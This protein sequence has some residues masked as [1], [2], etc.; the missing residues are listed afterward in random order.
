MTS[1]GLF[2]I[3]GVRNYDRAE[4]LDGVTEEIHLMRRTLTGLGLTEMFPFADAERSHERLE[5]ELY[6]WALASEESPAY[7]ETLLIY[8]TG[9]GMTIDGGGQFRLQLSDGHP[10]SPDLLLTV[11]NGRKSLRQVVLIL[12]ACFSEPGVDDSLLEMRRPNTRTAQMDFW[13]I[14]SSRRLEEAAQRTFAREFA[15]AVERNSR[16]SWSISHFEPGLIAKEVDVA[17]GPGQTVWL[18]AGHSAAGCRV[19]P[20][21]RYQPGSPPT[22]LPIADDWAAAARG[23]SAADRPGFFFTG[24]DDEL[25]T[26]RE[27]IDGDGADPIVIVSGAAG[28]G[29]S[30]LLG[31]LVLTAVEAEALPADVRLRW[32]ALSSRI[33]AARGSKTSVLIRQLARQLGLPGGGRDDVLGALRALPGRTGVVLDQLEGIDE[34]CWDDVL[35][36][37]ADVPGV[38]LVLGLSSSSQTKVRG[39]HRTIDLDE[40]GDR[41]DAEVRDYLA[42]R[43][44]LAHPEAT[45]QEL[46]RSVS[47]AARWGF[48]FPVAVVGADAYADAVARGARLSGPDSLAE[49]AATAAARRVCRTI[50]HAYLGDRAGVVIDALC[51]LCSYDDSIAVP[52]REWAAAASDP[53]GSEV[54]VDDVTTAAAAL[55]RF[56][57]RVPG[58]GGLDRWRPRFPFHGSADTPPPQHFLVRIPQIS[59]PSQVDWAAV[60]PAVRTL[61]AEG[62]SL[63]TRHGRMLDDPD[64]LLAVPPDLVSAAVRRLRNDAADR[65]RRALVARAVPPDGSLADRAL[66]LGVAA[67][68]YGLSSVA[69]ALA[70]SRHRPAHDIAWVQPDRPRT[71]RFT[72]MSTALQGAVA[73]TVDD[74]DVLGFWSLVD[75]ESTRPEVRVPGVPRTV[76]AAMLHGRVVCLVATWQGEIWAVDCQGDDEPVRRPDLIPP[77]TNGTRPGDLLVALHPGGR[78]VVGCRSEVWVVDVASGRPMRRAATLDSDVH[79]ISAAGPADDPVAWLVT[80]TCR[81]R[82]LRLD[83][84]QESEVAHFPLP[85]RP[86]VAAASPDGGRALVVDVGGGLNLRGANGDGHHLGHDRTPDI[87]AVAVDDHFAVVAGG[88]TG[89]PGWLEAYDLTGSASPAR[90]RLDEPPIG[91]AVTQTGDILVARPSGLLTLALR[92]P[93]LGARPE[94][95]ADVGRPAGQP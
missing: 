95:S 16:P 47:N 29:K 58:I 66:L 11:L 36:A 54:T 65:T 60:D 78:A 37:I 24:R 42:L 30:A 27:H 81:I 71:K 91:V 79:T 46:R 22:R 52:A 87:R 56:V 3:S 38:R 4:N 75:G 2:C 8:C 59:D 43:L 84:P 40:L 21:P 82:R 17:L 45:E 57:E 5:S 6:Q 10:Y 48:A 19:L 23:V 33:I 92:T 67:R 94:G 74:E 18:G 39:G 73:V 70:E 83:D 88:P 34:D 76:T 20:N 15:A 69:A 25:R 77:A 62:A 9:H 1:R 41:T 53:S 32:P 50:L 89:G 86:L 49:R 12:D 28:S 14:G 61:V 80:A 85:R 55:G 72:R 93:T 90:V 44:G 35:A 31:H 13:G 68:R 7:D 51:A 26:L 63:E 64:F